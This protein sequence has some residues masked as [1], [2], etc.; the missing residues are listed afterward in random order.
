MHI[1]AQS[2]IFL[3]ALI[4]AQVV[5]S[6][7]DFPTIVN[8]TSPLRLAVEPACGSLNSVNFTEINTGISMAATRYV[9]VSSGRERWPIFSQNSCCIWWLVDVE[10]RYAIFRPAGWQE[11]SH[12]FVNSTVYIAPADNY[13]QRMAPFPFLLFSGL[14]CRLLARVSRRIAGLVMGSYGSRIWLLH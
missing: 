14:R 10:W 9:A 7:N 5:W 13:A 2:L 1:A 11:N 6:S 12:S 8:T 4:H 3:A